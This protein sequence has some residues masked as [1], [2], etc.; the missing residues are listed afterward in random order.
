MVKNPESEKKNWN[1]EILGFTQERKENKV[2]GS[3]EKRVR[4]RE[5]ERLID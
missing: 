1:T 4:E 2:S 3:P 5:G